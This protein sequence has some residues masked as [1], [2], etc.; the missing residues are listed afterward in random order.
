MP[1]VQTSVATAPS[2]GAAA[3][4]SLPGTVDGSSGTAGLAPVQG[5]NCCSAGESSA[6]AAKGSTSGSSASAR[7][8]HLD[9]SRPWIGTEG[10]KKRRTTTL[11]FVLPDA[12]VVIFTVNQLSPACVGIGHFSYRGHAGLNRVRFAGRVHGQPLAPGTYRI[13][14]RTA[15][16]RTVRRVTLVVVDGPAPTR[17]ELRTLRAA[18][19]CGSDD[20][21]ASYA[22]ASTSSGPSGGS[23]AAPAHALPSAAGPDLPPSIAAPD[24]PGIS[25]G[26]LASSVEQTARAVRPLLVALLAIAIVL[27]ALA[28]APRVAVAGGRTNDLLARHRME[29]AALG[30]VALVATAVAFLLS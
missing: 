2:S 20:G 18:N 30:A 27:L 1:T 8:H 3:A 11:T 24:A 10:P 9:S 19:V 7:V 6:G 4:T 28:S 15:D 21:T 26:V 25:G 5:S 23:S 17:D 22:T 16:G 14:A 13:S 29:I 12:A